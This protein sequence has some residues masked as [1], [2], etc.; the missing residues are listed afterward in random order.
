MSKRIFQASL[1]D[2]GIPDAG[3][4]TA[5]DEEP[6]KSGDSSSDSGGRQSPLKSSKAEEHFLCWW[7][8]NTSISDGQGTGSRCQS[9]GTELHQAIERIQ[10][11]VAFRQHSLLT[12]MPKFT[13]FI[14]ADLAELNKK[15]SLSF[16]RVS[17]VPTIARE[18]T[19]TAT[20]CTATFGVL[21]R[22]TCKIPRAYVPL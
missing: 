21:T 19:F 22:V 9:E 18:A 13:E 17:G 15:T 16:R 14:S 4:E 11:V 8:T 6:G 5:D 20:E 1:S 12:Q 7:P 2:S 3:A 10:S